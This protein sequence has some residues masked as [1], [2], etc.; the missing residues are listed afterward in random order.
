MSTLA[1]FA[2]GTVGLPVTLVRNPPTVTITSPA[3]TVS[4]STITPAWTYNSPIGR[5]QAGYRLQLRSGAGAVLHDTGLVASA[6]GSAA[7]AYTLT[8][9]TSY[10]LYVGVNDG[11]D[12]G[13]DPVF[14][15]SGWSYVDFSTEFSTSVSF[16]NEPSVGKVYEIGING[17]GYMLADHPEKEHRYRR[18]TVHLEPQRLAT[19]ATPF[20]ESI[21]RYSFIAHSD[22]TSGEGQ[23]YL[24]RTSTDPSRYYYSELVN[25]FEQ[26][27]VACLPA[28]QQHIAS[29]YVGANSNQRAVVA[30]GAVYLQTGN[31][32]LTHQATPGGGETAITT[33]L[34][35]TITDLASDGNFWYATDGADIYREDGATTPGVIWSTV[36]VTAIEWVGDRLAG[37]DTATGPNFTTFTAAGAEENAGGWQTFTG[38]TLRGLAGGDGWVWFGA[39]YNDTGHVRAYQLGGAAG[40]TIIAFSLPA[41]ETVDNLYFYLGNVFVSTRTDDSRIR[42][43]RCVPTDGLLT[44]QLVTETEEGGDFPVGFAGLDK[45]VAF[46]WYSMLR[47]RESGIGVIDLET[48]G[49]ARWQKVGD[50]DGFFGRNIGAVVR[51]A[52]AFGAVAVS[53]GADG[54]FYGFDETPALATGFIETSV[55]DLASNVTKVLADVSLTTLPLNGTVEVLYSPNTNGTF[56]S[57]GTMS[58]SGA[59]SAEFAGLNVMAS[60]FGF[61]LILT[62]SGSTG[63][64]VKLLAAKTHPISLTDQIVVLPVDCSD[65][66]DGLNGRPLPT[67]GT[68]R[69]REI[70]R[71]LEALV[72]SLVQ[73]QD[74]DWP[75]EPSGIFEV[76]GCDLS[77]ASAVYSRFRNKRVQHAYAVLTLRRSL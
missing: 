66:R 59:T 75:D 29:T 30:G 53:A 56:V 2:L 42:I 73:L 14:F 24:N 15:S 46:A 8:A 60:S 28:L 72:G 58:G 67:S 12:G 48:G 57:I 4:T 27:Q 38:A 41:G 5:T 70:A 9:F 22:W 65:E 61:K 13:L 50:D 32:T 71:A 25:P 7:L 21:D 33:G 55:S 10:R 37:L 63:P 39:N 69:G 3:G 23:T 31:S 19:G 45:F 34:A 26:G 64:T 11:L 6:A 52:G 62:P 1:D 35:G 18:Q 77:E 74:V 43:Y 51:W 36:D 16:T 68:D 20:S 49:Y 47:T 54:G 40:S 76:Q 44:P 17:E